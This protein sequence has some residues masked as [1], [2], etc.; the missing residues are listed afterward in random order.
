M[1]TIVVLLF[2]S[3]LHLVVS[4]SRT[5]KYVMATGSNSSLCPQGEL[6]LSLNEYAS[7]REQHFRSNTTFVFLQGNHQLDFYV[8]MESLQNLSLLG[9]PGFEV[10]I[11]L[12]TQASLAL[13]NCIDIEI[14]SLIFSTGENNVRSLVFIN[15]LGVQITNSSFSGSSSGNSGCSA[16]LFKSSLVEISNS[17]FIGLSYAIMSASQTELSFSGSNVFSNNTG[18]SIYSTDSYVTMSG[19]NT[20]VNNLATVMITDNCRDNHSLFSSDRHTSGFGGAIFLD[21]STFVLDGTFSFINNSA[22]LSGGAI[23]IMNH[24]VVNIKS[25]Y[26][27]T[28]Q[29]GRAVTTFQASFVR[30][31]ITP[32]SDFRQSLSF[33]SSYGS[34][35]AIYAEDS[36]LEIIRATFLNNS[37]PGSGGALHFNH[38]HV[39]INNITMVNNSA[40]IAGAIRVDNQ[41]DLEIFGQNLFEGGS[42]IESGGIVYVSNISSVRLC[43]ENEFK[44]NTAR[45]G[46]GVYVLNGSVKIEGS[47]VFE[48]NMGGRGSAI[49]LN[50]ARATF[51][52]THNFSGN[53]GG[54][55]S[56]VYMFD[57]SISFNGTSSFEDNSA[58]RGGSFYLSASTVNF[59]GTTYFRRNRARRSGGALFVALTTVTFSGLGENIFEDNYSSQFGGAV[60]LSEGSI[61]FNGDNSTTSFNRNMANSFGGAIVSYDGYLQLI[62]N[63]NFDGNSANLGGALALYGT[64]RLRLEPQLWSSF[65]NN[66]A[67]VFG[68]AIF[69]ADSVTS[70]QCSISEVQ[71]ECFISI[72][73][74]FLADISLTFINNSAKIS[75]NSLYGGQLD[76]CRLYF[77]SSPSNSSNCQ[78]RIRQTFRQNA[79]EVFKNISTISM[80]DISSAPVKI[81]LCKNES[82]H[83]CSSDDVRMSLMPGQQFQL[84][85]ASFG[86]A[87]HIVNSTVLSKN[88]DF[89]SDYRLSPTIQTTGKSC[90]PVTYRMFSSVSD[91]RSRHQLYFD[92]PCQSLRRGVTLRVDI[93]PCPVGFKLLGE[94]CA[95]EDRLKHFTQ[96]CF[97]DN[98]SIERTTNNFWV[99]QLI[100]DSGLVNGIV[101][102]QSGCPFDYCTNSPINVTLDNPDV[103]CDNNR[104]GI[105]C[106]AC[107]PNFSLTLGSLHCLPCNNAYL[108]LIIPFAMAGIVLVIVIFLLR[109][110]VDVGTLNGLIFYANIIQANHQA[111][112]PRAT[113]N[114]FTVFIAWLNLDLGIE[115]CFYSG[116]DFY[117]YSWLQFLFPFY[118][119]FLIAIIIT[120]SHYSHRVANFL[121]QNPVA[122]LATLF[123]MS[124]SKMLT[125]IITPLTAT[126]LNHSIPND[127]Y[128]RVWLYDANIPYFREPRHIVLGV[129]AIFALV[130]L[131]LPYTFLLLCGHWVQIKSHWR[132]LSWINK[133]KPF[134]DAYHAPYKK[135]TR[136]WT[137]LLLLT[138]CGLFL[139]FAFNSVS[140]G[141][142]LRVNLLAVSSVCIA[143]AVIKERVYEKHYNDILE[144]SFLLNLCVFTIATLFVKD[145]ETGSQYVLSTISVGFA[146]AQF[147][148]IV[149]FH[150][151]LQMTTT[152]VWGKVKGYVKDSRLYFAVFGSKETVS[153]QQSKEVELVSLERRTTELTFDES[154]TN[155][156][157]VVLREPLLE[158]VT[159]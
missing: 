31:K 150:V 136:Y 51:I 98:S 103:Q 158:S 118:V 64:S 121:G 2:L 127:T 113:I 29:V 12:N 38:S 105:L 93:L 122:V 119:W 26:E 8:N 76:S 3:A 116:L 141:S 89:N 65:T 132:A 42:A 16:V 70:S 114:F 81:C 95:C 111:F 137:G 151:Y 82:S 54:R 99:A 28:P 69:F 139:T 135:Q 102:H 40:Y 25:A 140:G 84:S 129:F 110:T 91:I 10:T 78:D 107:K 128:S 45:R 73:S 130:F 41:T 46:G 66:Q 96:N 20:F 144:S 109:L 13:I 126:H 24:S 67:D 156:T 50:T 117:T 43:G 86:Q 59:Y 77:G 57:A 39:T 22:E 37:S 138:R 97:I 55:G 90:T 23:A 18:G 61:I 60:Y 14:N 157:V 48:R 56:A 58:G 35:G 5:T 49:Y 104:S 142:S 88:I 33:F 124:Y 134:M 108:A 147:A 19:T 53:S 47:S 123:L 52:G 87:Q 145:E 11:S 92:G 79:L 44:L 32:P 112:F 120:A 36:R 133:L 131:F 83:M 155:S 27:S 125:A 101:L 30:N 1:T 143:L 62:S 85:L 94:E 72:G 152:A 154:V 146:F 80:S 148:G 106:G 7:E 75:G 21:N 63:V 159:Y 9:E 17:S 149:L 15:T 74:D 68:G 153:E 71:I 115:T 6:C 4:Q 100:N 34:G